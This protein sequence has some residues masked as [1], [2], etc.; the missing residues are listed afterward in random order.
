MVWEV[1]RHWG[2]WQ[3][4]QI[5][6]VDP[7]ALP[8]DDTRGKA[9][10]YMPLVFYFFGFFSFFLTIPRPWTSIQLQRSQW[11]AEN[12]AAPAATDGRFKAGGFLAAV[13]FAVICYSLLHSLHYYKQPVINSNLRIF[14]VFEK[15]PK[16]LLF[17]LVFLALR[18]A[19]GI[20]AT[21]HWPLSLFNI[22]ANPGWPFGLGYG[23]TIIVLAT[24]NFAGWRTE[25]EDKQL[26][27]QRIERGRMIDADMG[28]IRKPTWW[29]KLHG[30]SHLTA[31]QR[32]M[33]EGVP[34]KG[35][36]DCQGTGLEMG[37][38][39]RERSRNRRPDDPFRDRSESDFSRVSQRRYS[40]GHDPG[41]ATTSTDYMVESDVRSQAERQQSVDAP[42]VFSGQTLTSQ[43]GK[44]QRV[45]SM[46]DV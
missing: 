8:P 14:Q 28:Y 11:Q 36:A 21:F 7:F 37:D 13:A 30:D 31:E 10:F 2:S 25:N 3:E 6:D 27:N 9:E 44:G 34:A 22:S 1:V 45:R 24:L 12:L 17:M 15:T 20:A 46:L 18:I 33:K 19:Y 35:R 23:T 5:L 16:S 39:P 29:R 38:L 26:L 40:D 41:I 4:R 32:L 43:A 42:S